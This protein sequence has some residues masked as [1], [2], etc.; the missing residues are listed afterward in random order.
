MD[1]ADMTQAQLDNV[2]RRCPAHNIPDGHAQGYAIV[3]PGR[4]TEAPGLW[5]VRWLAW[6]EKV[7][8]RSHRT[9]LI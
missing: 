7:F 5:Y 8:D 9:V 1:L 4:E 3:A 6:Q 2:F